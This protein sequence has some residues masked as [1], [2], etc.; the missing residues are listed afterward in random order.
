MVLLSTGDQGDAGWGPI[1]PGSHWTRDSMMLHLQRFHPTYSRAGAG[2]TT[3]DSH[4]VFHH[5]VW[6]PRF[7]A[8]LCLWRRTF[9]YCVHGLARAGTDL[10]SRPLHWAFATGSMNT[11]GGLAEASR[12]R[13]RLGILTDWG[14]KGE[15]LF[16]S[17]MARCVPWCAPC[18]S[19]VGYVDRLC[20]V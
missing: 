14:G 4:G 16:A 15:L 8:A 2:L 17:I 11:L 9:G 6:R 1:R 10:R 5:G 7:K 12:E 20:P 13:G 19:P 18:S 3:P